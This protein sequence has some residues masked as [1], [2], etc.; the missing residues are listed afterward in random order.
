MK[1]K[2][3]YISARNIE[4][5]IELSNLQT[6]QKIIVNEYTYNVILKMVE[7]SFHYEGADAS[8][9]NLILN[10][11]Q[12]INLVESDLNYNLPPVIKSEI[13]SSN[14]NNN[15]NI[16]FIGVPYDAGST[17]T[18]GSKIAPE[19][20]RKYFSGVSNS[21]N[22][23]FMEN[24]D[25]QYKSNILGR[26]IDIGDILYLPGES[27]MDFQDRVK[28]VISLNSSSKI[29]VM[30]GDHSISCSI[31]ESLST[32]SKQNI[33][34]VKFD[35]HY[36]CSGTFRKLPLN[37][38]N[39][40]EKIREFE[41]INEIIHVGVREPKL[42]F[43]NICDDK[44]FNEYDD[45]K[46]Y[47]SR[48]EVKNIYISIDIDVLEPLRNPGTT[49]QVPEGFEID[50]LLKYLKLLK[51]HNI[52]GADIVEYNPLLDKNNVSLYNVKKIFEKL[53]EIMECSQ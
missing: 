4:N 11:L 14:V 43:Y 31:V 36:D 48:G 49:Y 28:D 45:F 1:I 16:I 39:Y 30:G 42:P 40:I 24:C 47:F 52:V 17:G 5:N 26:V 15:T 13:L 34:F 51:K 21:Y 20:F 8:E 41:G 3:E 38:H 32:D 22:N 25:Y 12:E 23:L 10:Y 18:T 7:G 29:L 50:D 44:V 37:H 46:G 33:V 35:A 2:K 6:G 53:V 27:I 19:Y 9:I